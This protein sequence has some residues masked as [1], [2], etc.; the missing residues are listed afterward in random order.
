VTD[1]LTGLSNRTGSAAA[2]DRLAASGE[3]VA[4]IIIDLDAM[5][6]FNETVGHVLG[7]EALVSIAQRIA[8]AAGPSVVAARIGGDEFV[9]LS[10][11]WDLAEAEQVAERIAEIGMATPALQTETPHT[12]TESELNNARGRVVFFG[13]DEAGHLAIAPIRGKHPVLPPVEAEPGMTV[14]SAYLSF[15]TG[16]AVS[17][18]T[19][20]DYATLLQAA[21]KRVYA[22][23]RGLS[24][25]RDQLRLRENN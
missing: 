21:E 22:Q 20:G 12:L 9:L 13:P 7:D 19:E 24:N 23:K 4:C 6:A 5:K 18:E 11:Q 16:V 1:S 15:S 8:A 14:A 17:T 2:Y 25:W 10:D 3:S